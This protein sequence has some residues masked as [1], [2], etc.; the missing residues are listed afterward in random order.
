M[1]TLQ[2]KIANTRIRDTQDAATAEARAAKLNE[3]QR[4]ELTREQNRA[5]WHEY[6]CQLAESHRRL[7]EENAA[8]AQ[9]LLEET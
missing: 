7:S 1:D 2:K 9:M 5:A 6:F 4:K 8:R 3:H